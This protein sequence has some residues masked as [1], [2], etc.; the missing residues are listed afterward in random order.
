[1]S[2]GHPGF[3]GGNFPAPV[4]TGSVHRALPVP[5]PT[6]QVKRFSASAQP[7]LPATNPAP[8]AP[9]HSRGAS[10][11]SLPTA[12]PGARSAVV[13]SADACMPGPGV[14]DERPHTSG[15]PVRPRGDTGGGDLM[16]TLPGRIQD[17]LK[18]FEE[19]QA[20]RATLLSQDSGRIAAAVTREP[21]QGGTP[22]LTAVRSASLGRTPREGSVSRAPSGRR[23]RS[24]QSSQREREQRRDKEAQQRKLN[25]A[26]QVMK[27]LHK[28][29]QRLTRENE[30]LREEN[31]RLKAAAGIPEEA[32]PAGGR[33]DS[34]DADA[35]GADLGNDSEEVRRLRG[36]LVE[37]ERHSANLA[38]RVDSLEDQLRR[39]RAP[40]AGR[41][42]DLEGEAASLS[43]QLAALQSQYKE[44]LD[45][46]LD[47]VAGSQSTAKVNK[48]VKQFFVALRRKVH[49]D[50]LER[51]VARQV[52]NQKMFDL[53][54]ELCELHAQS[55]AAQLQ[56]Q[57]QREA[58]K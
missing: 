9:V 12:S 41:P 37:R 4:S 3:N 2:Q 16:R 43:A 52:W 36:L 19:L 30:A 5:P 23:P 38:R 1:M 34:D 39:Q 22:A 57:Q 33:T 44:L 13:R 32:A 17:S 53:E 29:N 48:E 26:E 7:L 49:E 35:D 28:K 14:F 54:E 6:S 50:M 11:P 10:W 40:D 31:S 8:P 25:V 24:P 51:E 45:C 46:K 21:S 42:R 27:K 55:R 20:Q 47:A 15:P 58:G 56:Q 18:M